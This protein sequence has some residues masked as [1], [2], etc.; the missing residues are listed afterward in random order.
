MQLIRF[1]PPYQPGILGQVVEFDN[2]SVGE[3]VD[4]AAVFGDGYDAVIE[5]EVGRFEVVG[6]RGRRPVAIVETT[7]AQSQLGP[8]VDIERVGERTVAFE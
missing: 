1:Q 7:L 2:N 8:D 6:G 5:S 3:V 4:R